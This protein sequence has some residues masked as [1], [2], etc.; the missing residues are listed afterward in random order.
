MK[1]CHG[2]WSTSP[3]PELRET[4]GLTHHGEHAAGA[5]FSIC[6]IDEK[7]VDCDITGL[8]KNHAKF[9]TAMTGGQWFMIKVFM[10]NKC[11]DVPL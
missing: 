4:G 5:G 11:S 10:K 7:D 8:Q 9:L 2:Y 1:S 6:F 3:T